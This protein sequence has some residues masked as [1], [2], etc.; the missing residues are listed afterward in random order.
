MAFRPRLAGSKG[1]PG[2]HLG[3][4]CSRQPEQ[5]VPSPCQAGLGRSGKQQTCQSGWSGVSK[6]KNSSQ[7]NRRAGFRVG[8]GADHLSP[9]RL[10]L[11]LG[12]ALQDG[13]KEAWAEDPHFVSIVLA[14]VFRTDQGR[15]GQKQGNQTAAYGE[16]PRDREQD[17]NASWRWHEQNFL[18][19]M[20][21]RVWET[22]ESRVSPRFWPEQLEGWSCHTE[23]D[24]QIKGSRE[25]GSL[26]LRS[27]IRLWDRE[28]EMSRRKWNIWKWRKQICTRVRNFRVL[29]F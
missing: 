10:K 6:G 23:M 28:V 22:Q 9:D 2:G 4:K 27:L 19:D 5:Q 11:G 21:W 16:N 7:G 25:S 13:D 8:M 14:T 17:P 29:S 26:D 1:E 24:E 18:V 20:T 15:E 3:E 12:L